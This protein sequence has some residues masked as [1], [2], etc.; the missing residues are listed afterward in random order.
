MDWFLLTVC[1]LL[2]VSPVSPVQLKVASVRSVRL[3]CAALRLSQAPASVRFKHSNDDLIDSAPFSSYRSLEC[4]ALSLST[5]FFFFKA[6]KGLVSTGSVASS[7]TVT[8][9]RNKNHLWYWLFPPVCLISPQ[10]RNQRAQWYWTPASV[11]SWCN[12]F[13]A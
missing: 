2:F 7:S 5:L 6:I 1:R 13:V 9:F 10:L 11:W 12:W 8:K 4:R 3:V